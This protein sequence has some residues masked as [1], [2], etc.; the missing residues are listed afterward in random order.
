MY[1]AVACYNDEDAQLNTL[2]RDGNYNDLI[3]KLIRKLKKN[4]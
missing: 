1:S 3:T 2:K 4:V